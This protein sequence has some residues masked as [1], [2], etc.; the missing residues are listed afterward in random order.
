MNRVVNH[1]G[2]PKNF[3]YFLRTSIC[4]LRM[5]LHGLIQGPDPATPK[6]LGCLLLN[7]KPAVPDTKALVTKEM[8]G[9]KYLR[10]KSS[11]RLP[12]ILIRFVSTHNI[13]LPAS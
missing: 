2:N 10:K 11:E 9:S 12:T 13:T 8:L 3:R 4:V 5:A 7:S 1:K 6:Y